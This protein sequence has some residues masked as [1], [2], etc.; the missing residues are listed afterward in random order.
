[1]R[2]TLARDVLRTGVSELDEINVAKEVFARAEE[3]WAYR[4]IQL[5]D[6]S[7]AKILQRASSLVLMFHSHE[8]SRRC[9]QS[10]VTSNAGLDA[11]L[12]I[13]ADDVIPA[14]QR[15]AIPGAGVEVQDTPSFSENF[16]SREKIQY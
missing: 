10:C 7:G 8:A 4:Q 6:E 15:L 3:H 11:R 16:G 12:L 2:R 14:T 9:R 1:M 13:R 5:I